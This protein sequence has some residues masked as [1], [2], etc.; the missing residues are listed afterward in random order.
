M[1]LQ[2]RDTVHESLESL[3]Q[4]E[5]YYRFVYSRLKEYIS[6]RTLEAGAGTGNFARWARKSASEYCVSDVDPEY[7]EALRPEFKSAFV[8]NILDP[9][10]ARDEHFDTIITFNVLEHVRDDMAALRIL[11]DQL[12]AGGH[13]IVLVPAHPF[14]FGSLD[15]A[16]GHYRR[17]NKKQMID[18]CEAVPMRVIKSEYLNFVGLLGWLFYGKVLR[19]N[20][21]PRRM[22]SY[23][24][25]FLPLLI[26][27]RPLRRFL[28][29]SLLTVARK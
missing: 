9:F 20:R 11:A 2:T 23:F 14:L 12:V 13:L 24:D 6:G 7:V 4:A 22:L 27:E 15:R 3:S 16:F 1:Y 10:P 8:W 21:L 5:E 28:G 19:T 25:L 26:M 17:Y 18:L 29:M